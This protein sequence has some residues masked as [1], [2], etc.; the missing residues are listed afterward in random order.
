MVTGELDHSRTELVGECHGGAVGEL[1]FRRGPGGADARR[2]RPQGLDVGP[3]ARGR[4]E[5]VREGLDDVVGCQRRLSL[6]NRD[7][8]GAVSGE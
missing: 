4:T 8:C 2:C 7:V 6:P 1:A 3:V 5:Q